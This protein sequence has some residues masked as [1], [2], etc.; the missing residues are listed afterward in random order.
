MERSAYATE[1]NG[2]HTSTALLIDYGGVLTS[3]VL[4]AFSSLSQELG[5]APETALGLLSTHEDVRKALIDHEIGQLAEAEFEQIFA[6]ALTAAGGTV[7]SDGLLAR[8][9]GHM[10]LDD[11]MIDA[12]RQLRR[13]GVPVALVSNSLGDNCYDRI[14]LDELFDV[15]VISRD[16]GIRKPSRQIY[17]IACEQLNVAP[18]QCVLVD[19][20]EQNLVG[21][22][23]LGIAGIHHRSAHETMT[24]LQESL[25]IPA[26]LTK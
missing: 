18:E 25:G 5:L 23:R 8:L 1:T 26:G 14:D 21:A 13:Q 9:N 24:R 15:S 6:S 12:V 20:L 16:V 19:D 7:G 3:S 2:L 11:T 22:A 10:A 4:G 17:R